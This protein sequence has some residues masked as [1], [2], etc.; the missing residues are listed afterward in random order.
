LWRRVVPNFGRI[1]EARRILRS[2]GYAATDWLRVAC[3]IL[4]LQYV[5]T[6]EFLRMWLGSSSE[7]R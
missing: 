3:V 4:A 5:T 7:R 1:A 6:F 2:M